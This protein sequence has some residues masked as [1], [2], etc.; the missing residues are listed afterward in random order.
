[1]TPWT[2][3]MWENARQ[4]P[5]ASSLTAIAKFLGRKR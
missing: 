3:G 1:V 5:S 4:R 2:F